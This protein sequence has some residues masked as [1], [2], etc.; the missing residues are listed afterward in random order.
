[1]MEVEGLHEYVLEGLIQPST[2]HNNADCPRNE[3]R[4]GEIKRS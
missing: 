3:D 2:A 1:M 4:E